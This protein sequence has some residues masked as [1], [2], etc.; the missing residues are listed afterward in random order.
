MTLFLKVLKSHWMVSKGLLDISKVGLIG[1]QLLPIGILEHERRR[2]WAY[3]SLNL[4]HSILNKMAL[5]KG[6]V[7]FHI[8]LIERWQPLINKAID[9]TCCITDSFLIEYFLEYGSCYRVL[10][11]RILRSLWYHE[12]IGQLSWYC[13][14]FSRCWW[15]HT[16]QWTEYFGE[17]WSE[18]LSI[19]YRCLH[20]LLYKQW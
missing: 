5:P 16:S 20:I 8:L 11:N 14:S 3:I 18:N 19:S 7:E 6:F 13:V 15:L 9:S 2:W 1:Y 10:I 17:T 12:I 4:I